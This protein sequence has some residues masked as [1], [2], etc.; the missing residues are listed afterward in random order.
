MYLIERMIG[1]SQQCLSDLGAS[2]LELVPAQR[3]DPEHVPHTLTGSSCHMISH[4]LG[5]QQH[6]PGAAQHDAQE[7]WCNQQRR[8]P[9]TWAL[10]L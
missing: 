10:K 4:R 5:I 6:C 1:T 8:Y 9:H 3:N 2:L 7:G